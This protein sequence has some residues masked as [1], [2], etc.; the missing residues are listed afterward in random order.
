[1]SSKKI[2]IKNICLCGLMV[3][4]ITICSWISVPIGDIPITLQTFAVFF[5]FG[6]LGG[7]LGTFTTI[8]YILLGAIGL[9]VFSGFRG[10][11]GMIFNTTGGYLFGFV[12]SA[13]IYWTFEKLCSGRKFIRIISMS[14]GLIV[15]YIT[16]TSWFLIIYTGEIGIGGIIGLCVLPF[17]VPDIIKI[18]CAVFIL[19][20]IKRHISVDI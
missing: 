17:I 13:L 2:S 9:P 6:F 19:N 20:R 11:I 12:F 3:A 16:G 7:R 8:V 14:A 5:T 18:F 15:C 4:L 10:G 1:M